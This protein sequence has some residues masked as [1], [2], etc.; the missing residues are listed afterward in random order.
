MFVC[1]L[2]WRQQGVSRV[3]VTSRWTRR[4][5]C[6]ADSGGSKWLCGRWSLCQG[7]KMAAQER[8]R[9][10]P[11]SPTPQPNTH[12]IC[13]HTSTHTTFCLTLSPSFFPLAHKCIDPAH[14]HINPKTNAQT[15]MDTHTSPP[16]PPKPYSSSIHP[17]L[18]F[19]VSW[20]GG[21]WPSPAR[22]VPWLF[23]QLSLSHCLPGSRSRE[24]RE[25]RRLKMATVRW[26]DPFP[27][28]RGGGG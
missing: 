7:R 20:A 11:P 10:T 5:E 28:Q 16:H 26:R 18:P 19:L 1:V 8:Q 14:T 17:S 24:R 3:E 21:R 27:C 6:S 12:A 4:A 25:E 2:A 9:D 23:D 13:T 22:R 15:H